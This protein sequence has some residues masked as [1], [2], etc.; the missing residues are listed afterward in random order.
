MHCPYNKVCSLKCLNKGR[1]SADFPKTWA[2][3]PEFHK[4]IVKN[5]QFSKIFIEKVGMKAKFGS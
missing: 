4:E 3:F 1:S 2:G 5:G